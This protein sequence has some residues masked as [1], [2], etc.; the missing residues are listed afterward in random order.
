ML[1]ESPN[2]RAA[3]FMKIILSSVSITLLFLTQ[4]VFADTFFTL[5]LQ[6]APSQKES[7]SQ[8]LSL[9][10][11]HSETFGPR[12][13]FVYLG[14][15]KSA[16]QAQEILNVLRKKKLEPPVQLFE[17]LVMELFTGKKMKILSFIDQY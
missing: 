7:L 1:A 8:H 12:Q 10:V 9:P 15:F 14:K 2:S 5:Q 3:P 4:A 6:A 13:Q 16:E 17:P 11:M